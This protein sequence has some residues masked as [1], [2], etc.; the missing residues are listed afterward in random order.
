MNRGK[1]MTKMLELQ[2]KK[3][4]MTFYLTHLR[5]TEKKNHYRADEP[6]LTALLTSHLYF[7]DEIMGLELYCLIITLTAVKAIITKQQVLSHHHTQ[8]NVQN[9]GTHK[10]TLEIFNN[11]MKIF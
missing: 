10:I 5:L 9:T 1:K 11:K 3:L 8:C 2:T 4:K 6:P 7:H